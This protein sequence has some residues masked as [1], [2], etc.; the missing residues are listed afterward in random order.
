MKQYLELCALILNEGA[1][2]PSR[3]GVRTLSIFDPDPLRFDLQTGFPILTTKRVAFN[4]VKGELLGFLRGC[5]T[6]AEFRALGCTI[7]DANA[8][9][10]GVEGSPNAWLTN[11]NRKGEDDLGRIY[12]AQWRGWQG[13][14]IVTP[15]RDDH[16]GEIIGDEIDIDVGS[17]FDQID[18]LI[19]GLVDDPYGRRH[20]VTAWNPGELKQMALPPC[21]YAFQ[22]YVRDEDGQR[23]L[24]MKVHMRSVDVFLGL[25][26]NISSYALLLAMLAHV[27]NYWPGRLTV[28][29]GDA[30][31]YEDHLAG[32]LTQLRRQPKPATAHLVFGIDKGPDHSVIE[33]PRYA[34]MS[35]TTL[36]QFEPHNIHLVGYD[37]HPAIAGK[38]AV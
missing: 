11:P 35:Y 4:Q 12:G 1:V 16:S 13:P 21:H 32:V 36:D 6:A 31:I 28:D 23:Y 5:T 34:P 20:L 3:T 30:H 29:M 37:P 26:F 18:N 7:W 22:C 17:T 14:A 8:N 2:R 15:E 27:T 33:G 10:A 25:P 38:M 9:A 24:D 19:A